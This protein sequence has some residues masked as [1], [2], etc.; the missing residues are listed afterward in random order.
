MAA[1]AVLA[2]ASAQPS[3][4]EAPTIIAIGDLHGDY[5]A[6]ESLM[7][8]AGLINRRGRWTGGDTI[9]V[10]TGDVPDRGPD[11]LKIIRH[12]QKLKRKAARK[13]GKVVTLVGNHEAMNATGDLRYVHPSEYEAF[14]T[15]NSQRRRDN[16][17]DANRDIIEAAYLEQDPAIA[18]NEIKA[19]W[20]AQTPLGMIE[21]QQAWRAGGEVGDWVAANPAVIVLQGSLFVHG[22]VS[23]K[24]ASHTLDDL[25]QMVA[26]AL[27][28][29]DVDP[30]SVINDAAGPLWYRGLIRREEIA[31]APA[32]EEIETP[33]DG[34]AAVTALS[35]EEEIEFVLNAYNIERI[36]VGHTPSLTGIAASYGGKL[37]QIDTGIAS[38]YGGARSFLR[39]EDGVFYAHDNGAVTIIGG[40]P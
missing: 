29:R 21:H 11:S 28:A 38:Y 13:G 20:E 12:L 19:R 22:G 9:F 34:E 24:Y 35:I 25:N 1:F 26:D 2:C 30:T 7:K 40:Q 18:S 32:G 8:E 17:Y 31:A 33:A 37:I 3:T 36:I 10:Q 15:R 16:L 4:N 23:E 27:I 39:I 14:K 6:Y 5:G